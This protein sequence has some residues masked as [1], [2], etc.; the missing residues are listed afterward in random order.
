MLREDEDRVNL[1]PDKV[2]IQQLLQLIEKR[3]LPWK[4][5]LACDG[6]IAPQGTID[7]RK[8]L[9]LARLGRPFH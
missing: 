3:T 6:K 9:L 1:P 4:E 5:F 8:L 2:S 7:F